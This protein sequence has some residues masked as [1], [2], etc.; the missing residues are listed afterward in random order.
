[1]ANFA[2]VAAIS[3]TGTVFAVN[4]QGISRVVKVGDALLMGETIRTTGDARAELLMEDGQ[5]LVVAAQQSVLLDNNVVQSEQ[6]PTAQDSALSSGFTPGTIIQALERGTD[7]STELEATAAGA[8]AAGA[9]GADGGITFVQLLRIVEGVD[10]LSFKYSFEPQATLTIENNPVIV[11]PQATQP[12]VTE[13]PVT[14]PPVTEPPVTQPPV[15]EPPVTQPPVTQP[16]VTQPPVTDPPVTDPPVTPPPADPLIIKIFAVDPVVDGNQGSFVVRTTPVPEGTTATYVALAVNANGVALASQPG[17]LVNITFADGTATTLAQDYAATNVQRSL[18]QTFTAAVLDDYLA[19]NKETFN[20]AVSGFTNSASFSSVTYINAATTIVDDSN[21]DTPETPDEPNQ[22]VV[23][24]SIDGPATVVEGN[25]TSKYTVT[26]SETPVTDVTVRLTYTGTAEDG[27]D[28]TKE[29]SVL[30][31]AGSKTATFDLDT[32]KEDIPDN[33]ETIVINLGGITGGG[34]ESIRADANADR[35]TTTIVDADQPAV[36]L[37]LFAV[38]PGVEGG[39]EQYVAANTIHEEGSNVATTGRYVVLAVDANGSPLVAVN[40]QT[41]TYGGTVTVG[42]G[43]QGDTATR[44]GV[45]EPEGD[46]ISASTIQAIVGTE[47]TISAKD[48]GLPDNNETFKLTLGSDWSKAG[49]YNETYSSATVT[50]TIVDA[51]QPAVKLQLFAVVP[52]VEGGPEQYVAAN[53]I[54]EEGSNVATTGRYVVLAV[55]ANGSPL[56]A[57]NLQTQ[58][59]GGT[60]TVGVGAQ[61]DTAT[62]VGVGEPEGDYISASTIQA[63]VGTEFTISAKDDGLPDNNETFK[64]T[65]GSDWSKA[66]DYNETYSSATVTTTI[67]DADQPA[68]KL[69][70]FAVVPGVEGGPEQYVAANTIHE[71]GSNVA[72]TGRYVVLAVD[73]NGSPLVAVNLQTQTY[74]GTV[75]VGV[76]AQGD[77]AT[78]VGVGEPEGDYISASTIQAIVGTEFTISAKDDGLPDNNETFKLTL[79]SDW[80]KAGDYNETYSSATVTTTIVDADQPAVKLQLFAVVPGVEGGPEQYV[81]AN[82]IHEEGSNV[83]TTGRY[84][85]LAVDANGSPLVAVNLQTQTYG[86]TVTVGVGAQGDTATRV[87]VGEPEGDYI[88]ASTIQAIVGTEFTISAKDDG[89][90]DNNETFKLTLGSDWSKAGDYNETYSSATVTTTIVDADQPAVKL[91]LFAVVPGVEGG[92][93][94]YVAANTIHEEGSNVATTGRYVVLAVDANGSPLVAVNLQTQTYGGTV[95]VGVGAQGDTATRVG[96][97]EPEGDYISASTIQAIVGTEFTISAKDDGLPDNN[98]TFKLTLGSDWSKAGDYN[99]T[100]SSATVTTTIV[101]ADQPAVKLQLFAV[102]PGVEGGPEQYVAAN[103]I[104]EEGSNVATTGRYVVLAVDANGSPL[105]AV[106]LQ[107]QTYG[108]T[109]T[110]GVGAQ[111]DTA[112]RVGVGEPEGDYISASTI[113]AIVGTEFTISAKDDGLPDNN[114]TFKLTLG[115]DWSK[116]GDYN[117]TYSSAT[118]TTTI[119]DA[120]QPAVKLQLFAVVPGVEGGPEQYVAANTIHEEGSNVATT[121]RYVVLAVDANGSPL[122]AVNLQTQTYGGT[123]TVGVGAQGDTATRVG[124][125]EP[126]GDYI[127]AS[128]IQAIVGTEFTISA[129]DDGLPD[130]NETFKLTLGSDWSKAGDYNETYSSATVTTTIVDAD[131]RPVLTAWNDSNDNGTGPDIG[132]DNQ[133]GKFVVTTATTPNTFPSANANWPNGHPVVTENGTISSTYVSQNLPQVAP[134]GLAAG[135]DVTFTFVS[136]VASFQSVV[137]WY[138]L[139]DPSVG[140]VVWANASNGAQTHTVMGVSAGTQMAFFMIPNGNVA[141]PGLLHDGGTVYFDAS[142]QAH[143]GSAGGPLLNSAFGTAVWFSGSADSGGNYHAIAGFE[144]PA[145]KSLLTVVMEDYQSPSYQDFND[146]VFKVHVGDAVVSSATPVAFNLGVNIDQPTAQVA[147][148]SV[149][150]TLGD[151]DVI[152]IAEVVAVGQTLGLLVTETAPGT[153]VFDIIAKDPLNPGDLIDAGKYDQLLDSF[154]IDVGHTD[155]SKPSGNY[156]A[157]VVDPFVRHAEVSIQISGMAELLTATADFHLNKEQHNT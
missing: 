95:T 141:N 151:G 135:S 132:F 18:G 67:V 107:T 133:T 80:S 3:G 39:P 156:E 139:R 125:G 120:D 52:G 72:T 113:Q 136:E 55:D 25:V 11:E 121:G 152:N 117:E 90:P 85:V 102:V 81:A 6:S 56:V 14:Q 26:L 86:G 155:L 51:D 83:A 58:T 119:V 122:V 74:G 131:V 53:T 27:T 44:V 5:P 123:V 1:M 66:G 46:Y 142:H 153:N 23:L 148:A 127:S 36:K 103:T 146:V 89:L 10:P 35:V 29:V 12:A 28:Y 88:S 47:F 73:A 134:E 57:V 124:V 54:H 50:T 45:G 61:G 16:P 59:Y 22:E 38:V 87:G 106:N 97:G 32:I 8:G 70:L 100:Y 94:Q 150:F 34:F 129:K 7:L 30:V 69:Q 63:I 49:D 138:D 99:E 140:H 24:V 112:T 116:A 92:P 65:L 21:P 143:T 91:Q 144:T 31:P 98:E 114:E 145:D 48:D 108:G 84:V 79:G 115:S 17:G 101:D 19:D 68:V 64:L 62:R 77:T 96:V 147:H 43:A 111:G 110:V 75:T 126:E 37:Q 128:T 93:E 76:G 154:R 9:A 109:V 15:T 20:V 41:Q 4:A 118:V 137:G 82:T 71:E 149:A 40:L 130:N 157:V 13:P 60:V 42:V 33:G 78:R 2:T 104:H 105:V